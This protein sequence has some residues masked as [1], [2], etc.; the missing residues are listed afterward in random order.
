MEYTYYVAGIVIGLAFCIYKVRQLR[1]VDR[2]AEREVDLQRQNLEASAT[3]SLEAGQ[4]ELELQCDLR[5]I[6]VPWGWP[7]N[8]NFRPRQHHHARGGDTDTAE[9]GTLHHW[10]DRLVSEEILSSRLSRMPPISSNS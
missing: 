5:E 7:G 4:Q 1:S 9:Q 6:P 3:P 10:V 8:R 2:R